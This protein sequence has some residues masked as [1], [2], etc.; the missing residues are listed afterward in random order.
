[1]FNRSTFRK[2]AGHDR[3]IKEQTKTGM[4]ES[5]RSVISL[6]DGTEEASYR[7]CA[8]KNGKMNF[9]RESRSVSQSPGPEE[10]YH[11]KEPLL[12]ESGG[13]ESPDREDV[14]DVS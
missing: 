11:A 6:S 2:P 1:M 3:R 9:H 13:H 7:S 4:S 10:P 8:E 5:F 12:Y 14:Q